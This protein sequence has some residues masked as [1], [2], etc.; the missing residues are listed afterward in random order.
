MSEPQ[1]YAHRIDLP[2]MIRKIAGL[3]SPVCGQ[4]VTVFWQ[5]RPELLR[6]YYD[7]LMRDRLV[8]TH[9]PRRRGS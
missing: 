4:P 8:V 2:V 9:Y 1:G 3:G 7:F 5:S 6:F